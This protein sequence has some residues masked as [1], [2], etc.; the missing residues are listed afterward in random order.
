MCEA[1]LLWL[2]HQFAAN[3]NRNFCVVTFAQEPK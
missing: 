1:V 3:G 2:S